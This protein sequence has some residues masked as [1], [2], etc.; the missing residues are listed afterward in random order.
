MHM[1]ALHAGVHIMQAHAGA[2]DKLYTYTIAPVAV[3]FNINFVKAIG[4]QKCN[5]LIMNMIA[6]S[7]LWSRAVTP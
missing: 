4:D 1:H 7:L 3:F 6:S 2:W 5:C